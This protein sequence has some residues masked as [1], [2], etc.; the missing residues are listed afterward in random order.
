MLPPMAIRERLSSACPDPAEGGPIRPGTA[1]GSGFRF[2]LLFGDDTASVPMSYE[3][4]VARCAEEPRSLEEALISGDG[5]GWISFFR[6][7]VLTGQEHLV[8][9]HQRPLARRARISKIGFGPLLDSFRERRATGSLILEPLGGS[10]VLGAR[11]EIH[12]LEGRATFVYS[13]AVDLSMPAI[14]ESMGVLNAADCPALFQT[15]VRQRRFL[16]EVAVADR[17]LRDEL[18]VRAM[19]RRLREISRWADGNWA[20]DNNVLPLARRSFTP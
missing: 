3:D 8:S 15:V 13:D 18:W 14:L 10:K 20:F 2:H 19:K 5:V 4:L 6:F 17:S 9:S 1:A 12:L 16:D 11:R 7:A